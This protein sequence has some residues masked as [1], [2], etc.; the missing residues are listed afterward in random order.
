MSN[1]LFLAGRIG[2][3]PGVRLG[4][5]STGR[6]V[7]SLAQIQGPEQTTEA[8]CEP[9]EIF[10]EPATAPIGELTAPARWLGWQETMGEPFELYLLNAPIGGRPADGSISRASLEALGFW[11]PPA[12]TPPPQP[13]AALFLF[14]LFSKSK[15]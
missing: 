15:P 2:N 6:L 10:P 5:P 4:P 9:S 12:P 8:E 3:P 7:V 11:V 13:D 1:P 14:A